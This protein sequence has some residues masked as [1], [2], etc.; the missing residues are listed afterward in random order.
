MQMLWRLSRSQKCLDWY[1]AMRNDER[2]TK[3]AV[4]HY[5]EHRDR[6]GAGTAESTKYNLAECREYARY[7]TEIEMAGDFANG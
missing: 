1:W 7:V 2:K 5:L 3:L 6:I 4:E